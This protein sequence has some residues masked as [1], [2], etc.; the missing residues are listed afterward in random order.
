[1]SA[2]NIR[3][4]LACLL[5]DFSGSLAEVVTQ[6]L[7]SPFPLWDIVI[8]GVGFVYK[9][10]EEKFPRKTTQ[11]L[12]LGSQKAIRQRR[13]RPNR[14]TEYLPTNLH[15]QIWN[16]RNIVQWNFTIFYYAEIVSETYVQYT[17]IGDIVGLAAYFWCRCHHVSRRQVASCSLQG[18]ANDRTGFH[19]L[20]RGVSSQNGS[21]SNSVASRAGQGSGHNVFAN[22]F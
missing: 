15:L 4:L 20:S 1:M 2:V 18:Q 13:I 10:L 3:F 7:Q 5:V 17:V 14:Q 22:S 19:T 16:K 21:C 6:S 12:Q 8:S 9:V 11:L